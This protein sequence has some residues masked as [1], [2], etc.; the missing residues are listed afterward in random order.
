[1]TNKSFVKNVSNRVPQSKTKHTKYIPLVK[2]HRTSAKQSS[3]SETNPKI[4]GY[5][6][7]YGLKNHTQFNGLKAKII[8]FDHSKN[9]YNVTIVDTAINIKNIAVKS[10]NLQPISKG[11]YLAFIFF[12]G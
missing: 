11:I 5:A 4:G 2:L 8:E 6:T 10:T 9:R 1:M 12:D 3:T 7:I